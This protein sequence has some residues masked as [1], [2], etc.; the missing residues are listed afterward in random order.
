[1][2]IIL[3]KEEI[4]Y[5]ENYISDAVIGGKMLGTKELAS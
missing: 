4:Q 2:V 5:I 3:L 1:M